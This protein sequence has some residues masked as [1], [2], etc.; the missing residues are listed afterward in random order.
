MS[1]MSC[2][3]TFLYSLFGIGSTIRRGSIN[4]IS[5]GG[6]TFFGTLAKDVPNAEYAVFSASG[7]IV[8]VAAELN[9]PDSVLS[10]LQFLGKEQIAEF[11]VGF[12]FEF[13][14]LFGLFGDAA[15]G[16]RALHGELDLLLLH[17][18]RLVLLWLNW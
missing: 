14:F 15:F 11:G 10:T 8:A 6:V 9:D 4:R 5:R 12:L 13:G 2:L 7:H 17:I 18:M 1:K 3:C 16:H